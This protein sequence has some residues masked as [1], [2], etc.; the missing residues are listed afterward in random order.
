MNNEKNQKLKHSDDMRH[1]HCTFGFWKY[2][3][4]VS[5]ND[6][7]VFKKLCK[8]REHEEIES[9]PIAKMIEEIIS[10]FPDWKQT[11][12]MWWEGKEGEFEIFSTS[13]FLCVDCWDM[14]GNEMNRII[15]VGNKFGCPLYDHQE[16]KRFV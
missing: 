1:E 13:Q 11:D 14:W 8:G 6:V 12:D 16:K 4:N 9:L 15:N 3:P 7:S 2:K 5:M 10:S